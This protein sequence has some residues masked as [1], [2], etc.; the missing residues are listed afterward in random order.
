MCFLACS[1][2]ADFPVARGEVDAW[3]A[4]F[5]ASQ[6]VASLIEAMLSDRHPAR[7]DFVVAVLRILRTRLPRAS[8]SRAPAGA[9]SKAGGHPE[10]HSVLRVLGIPVATAQ[11]LV[12]W[13]W[14]FVT[15]SGAGDEMAI[16]SG[17]ASEDNVM[18]D[19]AAVL[20]AVCLSLSE[21][22]TAAS[23]IGAVLDASAV[24]DVVRIVCSRVSLADTSAHAR[25]LY[26]ANCL[27]SVVSS[28]PAVASKVAARLVESIGIVM[29][30]VYPIAPGVDVRS[31]VL[32][33]PFF[34]VLLRAFQPKGDASLVVV[35]QW[36]Q[37]LREA[38]RR[39][40]TELQKLTRCGSRAG[41]GREVDSVL[42]SL[43][44]DV[45]AGT[46]SALHALCPRVESVDHSVGILQDI[47]NVALFNGE[48]AACE[49]E[50]SRRE[51]FAICSELCYSLAS[52]APLE[53]FVAGL[54]SLLDS[55]PWML[56]AMS[57][58]ERAL[59]GVA[60][61]GSCVFDAKE[62]REKRADDGYVGLRNQGFT[63]ESGLAAWQH[64]H[65]NSWWISDRAV[66]V[67]ICVCVCVCVWVCVCVCVYVRARVRARLRVTVRVCAQ[68]T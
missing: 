16:M 19:A 49:S 64:N 52:T 40:G 12:R 6:C 17:S 41:G 51:C 5:D 56:P 29:P 22:G 54:R 47:V 38:L 34:R 66:C 23:S 39:S 13:L 21:T 67:C 45:A 18:Q 20:N 8:R 57:T 36:V 60:R 48:A 46:V 68:A 58:P 26:V 28:V 14:A 53:A 32:P 10:P 7:T 4:A 43:H 61:P 24:D 33:K 50:E 25:I 37:V 63:C 65:D 2:D 3:K 44:S 62:V 42:F 15:R 30:P 9:Q 35:L 1:S 59:E 27:G 11:G 31:G 55:I